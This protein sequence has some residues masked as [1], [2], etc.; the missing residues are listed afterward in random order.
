[1]A[2]RSK[3][4]VVHEGGDVTLELPGYAVRYLQQMCTR[5]RAMLNNYAAGGISGV[6]IEAASDALHQIERAIS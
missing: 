5:E 2:S 6:L 4:I 3:A 1:M